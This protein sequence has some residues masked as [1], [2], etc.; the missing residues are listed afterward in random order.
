MEAITQHADQYCL[1]FNLYSLTYTSLSC[2]TCEGLCLYTTARASARHCLNYGLDVLQIY[3]SWKFNQAY[4][5]PHLPAQTE[6]KAV[7]K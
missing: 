6:M 5:I 2:L 1:S 7:V 3:K 4:C